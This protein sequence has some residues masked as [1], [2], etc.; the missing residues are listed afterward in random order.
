MLP[1]GAAASVLLH[2]VALVAA[3]LMIHATPPTPPAAPIMVSVITA[4]Q[5]EPTEPEPRQELPKPKP[6]RTKPLPALPQPVLTAAPKETV[7]LTEAAP[8]PQ[9]P[10]PPIAAPA[11]AAP[12]PAVIPPRFDAAYLDNSAPPYPAMSRRMGEQGKVQLRVLVNADGSAAQVEL[13]TSSGSSRL[14]QAALDAVK[15]WRFVPAKQ[16]TQPVAAWVIVPISF[17]LGG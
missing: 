3:Y 17:K 5:P 1:V 9:P 16:G 12:A 11:E 8:A 6:I 2:A 14:D 4:S 7:S 10:A 15:R 13:K